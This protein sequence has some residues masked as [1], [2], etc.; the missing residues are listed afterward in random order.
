M[1]SF[2]I[3]DSTKYDRTMAFGWTLV[4]AGNLMTQQDIEKPIEIGSIIRS[5]KI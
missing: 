5:Y 3:S 4:A 1:I 2:D